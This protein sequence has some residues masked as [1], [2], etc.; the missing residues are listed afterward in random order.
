M[1]GRRVRY[2]ANRKSSFM[3]FEQI[4][5]TK[6]P[7]T[8][9]NSKPSISTTGKIIQDLEITGRRDQEETSQKNPRNF[10]GKLAKENSPIAEEEAQFKRTIILINKK[11][12]KKSYQ[13]I[14]EESTARNRTRN[15]NP[16]KSRKIR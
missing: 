3:E 6:F 9:G 13:L 12:N 7:N 2:A 15:R 5:K 14:N 16:E 11:S 1:Q 4:T 10:G 8:G